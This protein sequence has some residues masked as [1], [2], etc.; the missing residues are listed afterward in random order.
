MKP[1]DIAF[2]LVLILLLFFRKPKLLVG[3]GL[4]C[5]LFSMPL[6]ALWVFFTAQHLVW[7]AYGFFLVAIILL[8]IQNKR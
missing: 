7:Y 6:F 2:F 5:L 1:Q 4:V 8:L 3:A